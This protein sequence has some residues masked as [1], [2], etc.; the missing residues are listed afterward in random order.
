M[1]GRHG[2]GPQSVCHAVDG[3]HQKKACRM[4][5]SVAW[6]LED[7]HCKIVGLSPAIG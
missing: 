7:W 6:W 1:I 3:L 2:V 5:C 4:P